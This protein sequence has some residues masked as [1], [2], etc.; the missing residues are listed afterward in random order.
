[1]KSPQE[2]IHVLWDE[3]ELGYRW[4]CLRDSSGQLLEPFTSYL[5]SLVAGERKL[6]ANPKGVQSKL[7]HATYALSALADFLVRHERKL[8]RLNDDWLEDLREE[9]LKDIR[10]NPISRGSSHATQRTTNTK[11]ENIY[12]FL[13]WSQKNR[14]APNGTIGWLKC[15]VRSS[16]P[17]SETRAAKVDFKQNHLYPLCYGRV[18][19][20]TR[21]NEGQ[22]CATAEDLAAIEDFLWATHTFAI[23]ERNTL[24][25]RIQEFTGWRNESINAL[26]V[27]Q[28][29]EKALRHKRSKAFCLLCPPKQKFGYEKDFAVD[30]LLIDRIVEYIENGRRH[31]LEQAGGD[32][33]L[34]QGRLFIGA[35]GEPLTDSTYGEIFT[36]AFKAIG[37]PKGAGGHSIRRYRTVEEVK[38]EISRR[39]V[40][41][42]PIDRDTIVRIVMELLGHN[43]EEAGR[44]YDRVTHLAAFESRESELW[45]RIQAAEL[46]RDTFRAQMA[47]L[48]SSLP[49]G[50]LKELPTHPLPARV[51]RDAATPA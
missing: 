18:G 12:K 51:A 33:S 41:G 34:T 10:S 1:M 40:S 11:L 35:K 31:L 30:W 13:H 28:F 19:G 17:E 26:T 48:L 44:A 20:S 4:P 47:R 9:M 22:Y 50:V 7:E 42:L 43:S 38:S 14:R 24:A 23:A 45:R 6:R 8:Y 5:E 15:R 49:E 21:Q 3:D 36:T 39:K 32:E 16:L 46:Q 25:L 27:D 29:T 2:Y 37:A